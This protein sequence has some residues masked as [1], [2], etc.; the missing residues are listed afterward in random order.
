MTE[1]TCRK[2]K[3]KQSFTSNKPITMQK[4]EHLQEQSISQMKMEDRSFLDFIKMTQTMKEGMHTLITLSYLVKIW[5][6][7]R[8]VLKLGE[9][10][11]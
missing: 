2:S 5:R 4:L 8:V 7:S 3:M 1:P 11:T 6:A 10:R 9:K